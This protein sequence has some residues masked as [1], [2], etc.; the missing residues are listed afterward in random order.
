MK[1]AI[2]TG[3]RLKLTVQ[4]QEK[5]EEVLVLKGEE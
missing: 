3:W 4:S 1:P 5:R 2:R